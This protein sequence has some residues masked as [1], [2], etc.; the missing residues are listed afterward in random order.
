MIKLSINGDEIPSFEA[1]G[2]FVWG[3]VHT[4]DGQKAFATGRQDPV[5]LVLDMAEA[6]TGILLNM[7]EIERETK[8]ADLVKSLFMA[9]IE[10]EFDD[11]DADDK[12]V[13]KHG[14]VKR[15]EDD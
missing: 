14:D 9:A 5:W 8:A 6:C 3:A 1:V 11:P 10:K 7:W 15:C 2:R 13:E 12:I 4:K